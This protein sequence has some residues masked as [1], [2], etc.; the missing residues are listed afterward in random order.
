V[1]MM[2]FLPFLG[3]WHGRCAGAPEGKR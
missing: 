3:H 2:S 1:I